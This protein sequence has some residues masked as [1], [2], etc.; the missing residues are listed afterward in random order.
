MTV[1]RERFAPVRR[2]RKAR[3]CGVL[4]W[5]LAAAA[6]CASGCRETPAA[7]PNLVVVLS[8]ALR[9]SSLDLY[10][11]PRPTAPNLAALTGESLVFE[12]H[13]VSYPGT[14]F[15][16][17]QMLTGRFM[18]PLLM[19]ATYVLAPVRAVPDDLFVLPRELQRAG[20][21]T[22]IVTSHPWF[23]DEAPALRYFDHRAV[24]DPAP[25]EAYASIEALG[26]PVEEF[27]DAPA[28]DR[29][30]FLYVHSMDTHAPNRAHPGLRAP[31][32]DDWPPQYD[33]YESEIRYTDRWL[34]WLI[35]ELSRRGR[36][37]DTL[38]V[39]TSDHG[40]ELGEMGREIWNWSHGY[41]LRRAQLHVPLVVRL[42]GGAPAD[43]VAET[44][45]HLD[46]APTLFELLLGEDA[47][48]VLR[49][50]RIDGASLAGRIGS[51][52]WRP[53][54]PGAPPVT[55]PAYTWR[56]WALH[57]GDLALHYDAWNDRYDAYRTVEGS[58][59]YPLDVPVTE[60][61]LPEGMRGE[62]ARLF[63]R[64]QREFV[65]LPPARPGVDSVV[66]GVPGSVG[67]PAAGAVTYEPDPADGL[68]MLDPGRLLWAGPGE[69]PPPIE[70]S[71]PWAPGV[72]R[73]RIRLAA[74]REGREAANRFRARLPGAPAVELDAGATGE[75]GEEGWLDLGT[76]RIGDLFRIE[77]SEPDG[78]VA[79]AGFGFQRA[80]AEAEGEP[81]DE[82]LEERLRALG[83]VD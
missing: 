41:T 28:D 55:T 34:G 20:Y 54:E 65:A 64:A 19:D 10:G 57:R 5:L 79:I 45:R 18:S 11:Y 36:L 75:P 15:S 56:Y 6:C 71:T 23:T 50:F 12:Q 32:S 47:E 16:V 69:S 40:E 25:G 39:F 63:R 60:D 46:L 37:D 24:V 17:S 81:P 74:P 26:G 27:L 51:G 80:G 33:L 4:A 49:R 78:G 7:R 83:Y 44:T 13:L 29:P 22:G 66:I 82:E 62:L 76:H 42:P 9:A 58:F 73:V 68:W 72:Y 21:R 77:I 1:L 14:P 38:L 61:D 8:D 48:E 53:P 70:L 35:G 43:R 59:N 2:R 67:G 3:S 31:P 30:F 52:G